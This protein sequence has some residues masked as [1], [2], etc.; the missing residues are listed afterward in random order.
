[1]DKHNPFTAEGAF[2]I[3]RQAA[4]AT[5]GIDPLRVPSSLKSEDC[6]ACSGT[7]YT[8]VPNGSDDVEKEVCANCGG[9]GRVVA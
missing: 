6:E 4:I 7:G 1:M 8:L 3:V 2:N 9:S 5:H